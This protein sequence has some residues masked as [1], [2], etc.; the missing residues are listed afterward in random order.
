MRPYTVL[1]VRSRHFNWNGLDALLRGQRG[2]Q[3]VD[4]ARDAET[5]ACKAA[6]HQP[7]FIF[8]AADLE[9]TPVVALVH[10]LHGHSRESKIVVIGQALDRRAYARLALLGL[11]CYLQWDDVSEERVRGIMELVRDSDLRVASGGV[12]RTLA[13]PEER[14]G[15]EVDRPVITER[16]QGLLLDMAAG[17]RPEQIAERKHLSAETVKR[18]MA[19][20]REKLDA[21]TPF[22][23]GM[24]AT[25]YGLIP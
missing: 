20:L 3:V 16:Q 10:D 6:R 18:D 9:D 11:A 17:L 24:K 21:T 2:V 19:D 5:A 8:L 23:L 7:A 1:L 13:T 15:G 4:V 25:L 14:A 12:A 22:T